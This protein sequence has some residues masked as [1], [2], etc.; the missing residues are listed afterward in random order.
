LTAAWGRRGNSPWGPRERDSVQLKRAAKLGAVAH[1]GFCL[2]SFRKDYD[3]RV[4][5]G[6]DLGRETN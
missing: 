3:K 5:E 2:P 6:A 1:K 4:T